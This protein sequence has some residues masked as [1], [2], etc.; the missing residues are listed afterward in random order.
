MIFE[1]ENDDVLDWIIR[2]VDHR[3]FVLTRII[4]VY[5]LSEANG[6][7]KSRFLILYI[8]CSDEKMAMLPTCRQSAGSN[9]PTAG[10]QRGYRGAATR[11]L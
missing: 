9:S 3:N 5:L 2:H 10:V 7:A 8:A 4:A 1:G 6:R 11:E